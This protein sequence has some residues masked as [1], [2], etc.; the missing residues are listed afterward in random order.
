V[1]EDLILDPLLVVGDVCSLRTKGAIIY[2]TSE[3]G[4]LVNVGKQVANII[5]NL[6]LVRVAL[7]QLG[8]KHA[9]HT[10]HG[11]REAFEI[12]VLARIG[13]DAKLGE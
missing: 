11:V 8:L 5:S 4:K 2:K 9:A 6:A 13:L 10:I 3:V 1:L 12:A 7:L